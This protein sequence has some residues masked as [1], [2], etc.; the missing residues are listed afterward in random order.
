TAERQ[1]DAKGRDGRKR[2]QRRPG[3]CRRRPEEGRAAGREQWRSVRVP[4]RIQNRR[5]HTAARDRA[6]SRWRLP[7]FLPEHPGPGVAPRC[8][9]GRRHLV[10]P[11]ERPC[12][13]RRGRSVGAEPG[14]RNAR[15]PPAFD[16]H[17]RRRGQRSRIPW[18]HRHPPEPRRR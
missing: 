12:A 9:A 5:R 16:H 14:Q 18:R 17:W 13:A 11:Q 8:R 4:R 7:Q 1:T 2:L 6:E 10:G 3:Q 15:R